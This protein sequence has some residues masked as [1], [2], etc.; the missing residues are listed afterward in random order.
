[1]LGHHA[2]HTLRGT[3]SIR[4]G[5][6]GLAGWVWPV[7]HGAGGLAKCTIRPAHS[8]ILQPL[9]QRSMTRM[10]GPSA[11][12]MDVWT[13]IQSVSSKGTHFDHLA[14]P[15]FP[16]AQAIALPTPCPVPA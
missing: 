10:S 16:R 7:M 4:L 6:I 11:L 3:T 12:V 5:R 15:V 13:W 9:H 1:M 8:R 2:S 14:A